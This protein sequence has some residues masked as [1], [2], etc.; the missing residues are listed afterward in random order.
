METG[1][2]IINYKDKMLSANVYFG[3]MPIVE[4]LE[5]GADIVI[6]GRTTDTGLTL[7][8]MIYEFGWD[9]KNYDL[10]A[11]GTIAGHRSPIEP[12]TAPA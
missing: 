5:R 8:P 3:A 4:A 7:A 6:T 12:S 11:A 2:S 9:K 1:E 10:M